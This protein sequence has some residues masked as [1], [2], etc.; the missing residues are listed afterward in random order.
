MPSQSKQRL[1][2]CSVP[3]QID[4]FVRSAVAGE[5]PAWS[6]L[7]A[8]TRSALTVLMTRLILDHA[9]KR[10]IVTEDCHDH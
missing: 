2:G 7:P 6:G 3:Q 9:S 1:A 5:M 8:E 10:R 4:L